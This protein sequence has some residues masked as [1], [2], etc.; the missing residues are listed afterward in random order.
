MKKLPHKLF[1]AGRILIGVALLHVVISK[2]GGW[3]NARPILEAPR[4]LLVV[5]VFS[6]FGAL[7]EA[8]RLTLLLRAQGIELPTVDACRLVAVAFF[9]NFSIPGGASGDLSKLYY[10]RSAQGGRGV[11]LATTLFVDRAIGFFSL[12]L[13]TVVLGVANWSFVRASATYQWL[14]AFAVLAMLLLCALAMISMSTVARSWR[15]YEFVKSRS[16]LRQYLERVS[17]ALYVYRDHRAAVLKSLW[18]TL[19]GNLALAAVFILLGSLLVP[20][21]PAG[22]TALLSLLGTFANA[23]TITPG[24]LGVGEAA[25]ERLFA[26]A[27]YRGG[28]AL[29]VTWRAGMLPLAVLG[30]CVYLMGVRRQRKLGAAQGE[31]EGAVVAPG[32]TPNSGFKLFYAREK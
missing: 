26:I 1:L 10:L 28:A 17:Q 31:H 18:L 5:V 13:I 7:V 21:A 24:G 4:F 11:E 22:G 2:A 12:L 16:T 8:K 19:L 25:F 3:A 27:G 14:F 20:G 29:L 32:E 15:W 23:I 9:F 30:F 6:L